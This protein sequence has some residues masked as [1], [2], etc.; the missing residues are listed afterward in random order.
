MLVITILYFQEV[1]SAETIVGINE[2][3]KNLFN[4][5]IKYKLLKV[6][7]ALNNPTSFSSYK[8]Y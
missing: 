7:H 1:L 4:K 2:I 6:E 8:N 3:K 5:S